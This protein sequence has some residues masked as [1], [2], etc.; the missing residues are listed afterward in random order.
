MVHNSYHILSK[1]KVHIIP[2]FALSFT[3]FLGFIKNMVHNHPLEF[4]KNM[5]HNH[6]LL[7][8][9]MV[10]GLHQNIVHKETAIS[11]TY[12]FVLDFKQHKVLAIFDWTT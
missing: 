12:K 10:F 3:K 9:K 7:V 1:D 4:M 8:E 6:P 11:D 5:A 2:T